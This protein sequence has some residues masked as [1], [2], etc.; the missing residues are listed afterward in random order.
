MTRWDKRL[1]DLEERIN[2]KKGVPP[3]A[4]GPYIDF[5]GTENREADFSGIKARLMEKFGTTEG[6]VFQA[7]Y[8]GNP[9]A[10]TDGVSGGRF[11]MTF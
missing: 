2:A 10:E 6:A 1:G 3:E 7:I 5:V 11:P 4:R 9:P 8:W